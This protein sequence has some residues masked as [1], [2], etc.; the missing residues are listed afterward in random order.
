MAELTLFSVTNNG[1]TC[2]FGSTI[3]LLFSN[4]KICDFVEKI[5]ISDKAQFAIIAKL[6]LMIKRLKGTDKM[7][8][9][10]LA[11]Y[12]LI[13]KYG[14]FTINRQEDAHELL[15]FL[16]SVI[17]DFTDA[18]DEFKKLFYYHYTTIM[19]CKECN[20]CVQSNNCESVMF[21]TPREEQNTPQQSIVDLINMN[22]NKCETIDDF[23]CAGCNKSSTSTRCD[24]LVA[25]PEI[26]L[27]CV[28]RFVYNAAK[29]KTRVA[30]TKNVAINGQKYHFYGTCTHLGPSMER[31]HYVCSIMNHV[32]NDEQII[33][34]ENNYFYDESN[35]YIILGELRAPPNPPSAKAN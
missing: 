1:N 27:L 14:N 35:S 28:R 10:A 20:H 4:R 22:F 30:L 11:L 3:V 21:L 15:Q 9:N 8:V 33:T 19:T 18:K 24:K 25:L 17:E 16:L 32:I 31:G 7:E 29:N 6:Q 34:H 12:G 23:K 2:Y 26:L 13:C 5:P